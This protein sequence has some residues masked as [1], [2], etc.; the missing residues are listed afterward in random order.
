M[1]GKLDTLEMNPVSA[2]GFTG[3]QTPP[4]SKKII[5]KE[6]NQGSLMFLF[7]LCKPKEM[8]NL[9]KCITVQKLK[10]RTR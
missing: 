2:L 10:K 4:L 3:L 1:S 8:S 5:Y 6:R 9:D 7:R